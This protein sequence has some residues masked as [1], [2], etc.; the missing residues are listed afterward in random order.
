MPDLALRTDKE[1]RLKHFEGLESWYLDE[2]LLDA[3]SW[4]Q[5][6]AGD[7]NAILCELARRMR[8]NEPPA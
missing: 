5:V 6:A 8:S 4:F 2:R 7:E 3:E 1:Y